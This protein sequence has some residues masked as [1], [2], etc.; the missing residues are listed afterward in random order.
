M[1]CTANTPRREHFSVQP[2]GFYFRK[3]VFK[4]LSRLMDAFKQQP[5]PN[6]FSQEPPSAPVRRLP[7]PTGV[8][9]QQ[10]QSQPGLHS[11]ITLYS[12]NKHQ[13]L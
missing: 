10:Q 6:Q 4:S 12:T 9:F 2:A 7:A 13:I 5:Q 8:P 1:V 3:K 11:P